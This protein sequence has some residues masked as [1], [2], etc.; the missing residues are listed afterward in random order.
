MEEAI[1]QQELRAMLEA[2]TVVPMDGP[3]ATAASRATNELRD[4]ARARRIPIPGLSDGLVLATARKFGLELLT[5][6]AHFQ[7]LPETLWLG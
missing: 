6:D 5:G 7:G 1:V 2:S 4:P 3:L